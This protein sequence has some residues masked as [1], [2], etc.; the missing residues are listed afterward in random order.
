VDVELTNPSQRAEREPIVGVLLL[1][2][3]N[4]SVIAAASSD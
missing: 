1:V 4:I 3:F 2:D